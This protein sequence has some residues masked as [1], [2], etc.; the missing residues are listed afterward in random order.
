MVVLRSIPGNVNPVS[1]P[2]FVEIFSVARTWRIVLPMDPKG[3]R[4][5]IDQQKT[6]E[7]PRPDKPQ[8]KPD[9]SPPPAEL[10]PLR[11]R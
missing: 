8:P 2:A 11:P 5:S 10:P 7:K 9:P 1:I 6:D 4:M 3:D